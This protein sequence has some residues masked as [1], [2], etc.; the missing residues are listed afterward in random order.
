[1]HA[2]ARPFKEVVLPGHVTNYM[3]YISTRRR[4]QTRQGGG[5]HPQSRMPFD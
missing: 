2:F 3:H 5:S 1:M 4:C